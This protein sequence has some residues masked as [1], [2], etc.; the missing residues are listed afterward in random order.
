MK[1]IEDFWNTHDRD[2]LLIIGV[3][4]ICLSVL[5]FL[6]GTLYVCKPD[7]TKGTVDYKGERYTYTITGNQIELKDSTEHIVKD[8]E[9]KKA[10]LE[11]R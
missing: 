9:L 3:G 7:T 5:F 8:E 10:V 1:V 11:N 2:V 4:M 6:A